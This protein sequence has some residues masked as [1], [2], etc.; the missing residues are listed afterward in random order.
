M[1]KFKQNFK[2]MKEIA[3]ENA[4]EKQEQNQKQQAEDKQDLKERIAKMD[5]EGIAYCPKC[6]STDLSANKRG[7]KMSTG[8]IGRNKIVVT[9]LK[10]GNKFKAGK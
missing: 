4:K 1:E 6:Y 9:C 7:W 8:L 3:K 10:C 2:E 5:K